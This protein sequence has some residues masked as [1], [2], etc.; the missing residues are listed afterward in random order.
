MNNILSGFLSAN[1]L[2]IG[3]D[4]EKLRLL[5]S[6]ANALA[7]EIAA[8]PPLAYRCALVGLDERVP[9]SDPV[10]TKVGEVIATKW[11]T[12]TNK[13]GAGPVQVHRA[14]LLRAIEIAGTESRDLRFAMTLIS[15]SLGSVSQGD[16]AERPVAAMLANWGSAVA[17]DLNKAWVN[18]VDMSLPRFAGKP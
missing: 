16:K 4:D 7:K 12:M 10:H 9:A 11:L 13:T 3:E 1:L 14:V 6:A 17:D 18:T 15:R 8:H 5:D 2:P